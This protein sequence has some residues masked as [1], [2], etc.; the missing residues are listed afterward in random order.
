[1]KKLLQNADPSL[2]LERIRKAALRLVKEDA[3]ELRT[4]LLANWPAI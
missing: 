4:M 1:M 3:R 2:A